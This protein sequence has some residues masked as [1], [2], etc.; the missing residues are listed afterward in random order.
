MKLISF[1]CSI[2]LMIGY[3]CSPKTGAVKTDQEKDD[4]YRAKRIRYE[5]YVYEDRIRTVQFYN[6]REEQSMPVLTLGTDEKLILTFDELGT[7]T[8]NFTYTIEHCTSVWHSSGLSPNEYLNTFT[9]ERI[10]DY[11]FST[12]TLQNF[13]HYEAQ[14][15]NFAIEPLIS[16]NYLL[17]V[18]R[19][20]DP[21]D[22]VLTRRFMVYRKRVDINASVNRSSVINDRNMKQKVN[23]SILHSELKI[24]N[25]FDEIKAVVTQNDRW[26]NARIS[27]K[28]VFIRENE[29]VYDAVD[30]NIF[31]GGNEFRRFDIRSMR[32]Y[33]EQV[34]SIT[35][36][37][38]YHVFLLPDK[39]RSRGRYVTEFDNNGRFF[40]R[41]NEG[42]NRALAA[43]YVFVHF[44]LPYP[45]ALS[46]GSLYLF[47]KFSD[48]QLYRRFRL[49]YNESRGGYEQTL[50]LKQGVYNYEYVFIA[51]ESNEADESLTEGSFFETENLYTIYVYHRALGSRYEELVGLRHINSNPVIR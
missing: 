16:G 11:R 14:F 45:S 50:F 10:T 25:P 24:T 46:N 27:T 30:D 40:T 7:G 31:N 38:L 1:A 42:P 4:Y 22:L 49:N 2:L 44:F 37:S 17:K 12:N 23:F 3:A 33:A 47:G 36:D 39:P 32:F 28:P 41:V 15:P 5:D 34:D 18:Y 43:D 20:N 29:L 9:E 21:D 35:R 26:D 51:D 13:V 19:N 6:T 8:S 48:W